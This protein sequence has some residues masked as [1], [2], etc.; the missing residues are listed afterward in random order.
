MVPQ[1][2]RPTV[3]PATTT[4]AEC[5]YFKA[6][7]QDAFSQLTSERVDHDYTRRRLNVCRLLL[8]ATMVLLL[9]V[10]LTAATGCSAADTQSVIDA[11]R[12]ALVSYEAQT[13]ALKAALKAAA[14]TQPTTQPTTQAAEIAKREEL[15]AKAR[16]TL[17]IAQAITDAANGGDAGQAAVTSATGIATALIPGAQAF[18]PLIAL[19]LGGLYGEWQRRKRLRQVQEL[20]ASVEALGGPTTDA[21]RTALLKLQSDDTIA[22]VERLQPV[23]KDVAAK[24]ATTK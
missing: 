15:A 16:E 8:G 9:A 14:T 23:A 2:E 10:V 1:R 19:L 3:A 12:Q 6:S 22:A 4:E 21:Q 24:L 17:A 18:S 20:V 13:A 5:E 11:Q 7:A